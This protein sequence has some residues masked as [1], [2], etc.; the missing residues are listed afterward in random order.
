MPQQR[1][2]RCGHT[3]TEDNT[4]SNVAASETKLDSSKTNDQHHVAI[5]DVSNTAHSTCIKSNELLLLH[6]RLGHASSGRIYKYL[7]S[8]TTKYGEPTFEA[9]RET[10]CCVTC[11]TTRAKE[12]PHKDH[13]GVKHSE[14]PYE[15][16]HFDIK[17]IKEESYGGCRYALIIVDDFTRMKHVHALRT[18]DEVP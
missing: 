8:N 18:K 15:Y 16:I 17:H 3:I 9:I 1:K 7:H 10:T 11:K 12:R 5:E 13:G 14:G 2:L 4:Y 6:K